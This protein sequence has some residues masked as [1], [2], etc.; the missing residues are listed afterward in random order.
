MEWL[1][2]LDAPEWQAVVG[3]ASHVIEAGAHDGSD[4]V[5]LLEAF[6]NATIHCFEPDHRPLERFF[7]RLDGHPRIRLEQ[8]AVS[9][10]AGTSTWYASHGAMTDVSNP[11]DFPEAMQLD[12]DASGSIMRPTGHEGVPKWVHFQPEGRV[13]LITLDDWLDEHEEIACIDLLWAD[14]QGAEL[15]MIAG[16]RR[17]LA[18]T[19][20]VYLEVYDTTVIDLPG[21]PDKLYEGQPSFDDLVRALPGWEF[22]G[23]YDKDNALFRNNHHA[24]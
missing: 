13:A 6:P 10:L 18:I 19:R 24:A 17:A 14:I 5:M 12:W 15:K 3:D 21:N 7:A 22:L 9:D 16:A 4:T 2:R 11:E 1:K 20:Y 23:L 8:K